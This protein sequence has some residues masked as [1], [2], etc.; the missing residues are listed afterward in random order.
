MRR[1][2]IQITCVLLLLCMITNSSGFFLVFCCQQF[3]LKQE[4][5]HYLSLHPQNPDVIRLSF[6]AQELKGLAWEGDDEFSLQ[7]RMYDVISNVQQ[8][9]KR[10]LYCVEDSNET[11]LIQ[12]FLQHSESKLPAK[13][14][15]SA[16]T[17][18]LSSPFLI[19]ERNVALPFTASILSHYTPYIFF[20][21]YIDPGILT[22][23]PRPVC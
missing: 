9:E 10:I 3:K 23:P 4:M 20:L 13:D 12:N 7:G 1:V 22:P 16:L 5:K 2:L 14:K 11:T 19:A 8:G 6:S 21:L 18:W 17:E 15:T